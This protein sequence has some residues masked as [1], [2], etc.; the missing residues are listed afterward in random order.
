MQQ[1]HTYYRTHYR[2]CKSLVCFAVF[3]RTFVKCVTCIVGRG[4]VFPL[5][6]ADWI[7]LVC[8]A[9]YGGRMMC[10]SHRWI[11]DESTSSLEHVIFIAM[12]FYVERVRVPNTIW[13][14]R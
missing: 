12:F 9:I 3:A 13:D 4:K 8:P 10:V 6:D 11:T 5:V 2:K 7:D 1:K 14:Q